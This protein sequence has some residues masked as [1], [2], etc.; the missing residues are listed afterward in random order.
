[1]QFAYERYMFSN[2]EIKS[3]YNTLANIM[4]Y[5]QF[6]ENDKNNLATNCLL[7]PQPINRENGSINL[8]RIKLHW[9]YL[10]YSGKIL[11]I[12]TIYYLFKLI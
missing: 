5:P 12:L 2:N 7:F 10:L 3:I 4:N 1:M 9:Y 8:R 11:I 6:L